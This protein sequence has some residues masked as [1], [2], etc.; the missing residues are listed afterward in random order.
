LLNECP[1]CGAEIILEV[2]EDEHSIIHTCSKKAC[3][4]KYHLYFTNSEIYRF[5]PS[6]IVSTVDKLAS[7]ALNR[8]FKNLIGGKLSECPK[9]HGFTPI[10]DSCEVL[11]TPHKSC[12]EKPV[13]LEELVEGPTLMIQDEMHLLREGF[14]T[15]DSHFESFLNTLLKKFSKKEFKYI[16][17]TATVAGAQNQIDHLYG[18]NYFIF[19]GNL[20]RGYNEEDDFFFK[21]ERKN[22]MKII[23]RILIGLKPNLRD[24]QYA[25]LLTIH[26]IADFI[27]NVREHKSI[28]AKKF[29]ITEKELKVELSKYQC[30]LTYHGKKADVFGMNYFLH[31]VVTSKLEDFDIVGKPL[32]G[33]N[34]LT[35][36]KDTI[37][38]IQTF[39]EDHLNERRL[40]STFATSVVSHG[41]DIDNWNIMIFQGITRDTSEYIQALSR[42]GRRYTGLIFLWFYPN[43]V[44]DLSYY[45]NFNL[46]HSILQQKVER[47]PIS[48]WTKLGFKQ[49]FTSIFCGTI[50]NYV[51][52]LV[53]K[54][55]YTVEDV[56]NFFSETKNREL[57]EEFIS[58][59]YYTEMNRIG[60]KWIKHKIGEEVE[61]RLDYLMKYS[62]SAN[63]FFFPNALRDSDEKF[64][65]TQYGMRGIQD[66]IT[67]KLNDNYTNLVN[68]YKK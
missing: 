15:I 1:V 11:E 13:T 5:L 48:R 2:D 3:N 16:S 66:E 12:E 24:N 58:E 29:S 37:K 42:A 30:L 10:N 31:T 45:K 52:N 4:K 60:A 19:P 41:V 26:H 61:D 44:R 46:Y 40:H 50:L 65:K 49:T 27:K 35:D 56:N 51:S 53:E 39:P 21:F 33:D 64:F 59:A 36:I 55:L 17:M 28:Y 22:D 32:T 62:G 43:R 25:S 9:G 57:L 14:G 7:V 20:P 38:S 47:T 34:T 6:L 23:Q 67:L 18:K 54:P 8:R 63:K 68:K